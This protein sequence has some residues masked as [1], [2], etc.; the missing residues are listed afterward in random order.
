MTAPLVFLPGWCVGR[1]PELAAVDALKGTIFDL[2]GYRDAPLIADF[3][4]A[5]D[6]LAARLQ[7]RTHLVGWSL[8]AQMA[9]AI[10]ARAPEKVG[11]LVLIAG[12]VSFVQRDGWPHAMPPE[13]LAEFAANVATDIEAILPRFVGGFNRGD[14]RAKEVTRILL[15][16]ADPLPPAATLATGL[17]WLRDVDLRPLAPR[18]TAPTLL[19]HGANDPLMPLAAAEALAALIP[20]ARLATFADCAHAPF[21]SRPEE[22]LERVQAFLNE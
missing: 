21:I 5:A 17:G 14:T 10:A 11:K 7:P 6:D 1:G 16:L 12:T 9:L 22:F 2:P 4:A 19:V 8:G 3:H 13:M 15:D 20:G 18:V